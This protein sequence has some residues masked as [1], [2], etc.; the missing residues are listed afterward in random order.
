MNHKQFATLAPGERAA[1]ERNL[2]HH[3]LLVMPLMV[4]SPV[5]SGFPAHAV[6]SALLEA[7]LRRL[8][9][10]KNSLPF[11][12]LSTTGSPVV[13]LAVST[14]ATTFVFSGAASL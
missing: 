1:A 11:S 13:R 4:M 7:E 12:A 14:T 6:C 2:Q 8:A 5:I 9:T 10:S 3:W